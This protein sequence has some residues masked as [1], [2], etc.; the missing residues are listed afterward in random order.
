MYLERKAIDSKDYNV[1]DNNHEYLI[2]EQQP[3]LLILNDDPVLF[4]FLKFHFEKQNRMII[5]EFSEKTNPMELFYKVSPDCVILTGSNIFKVGVHKV[6]RL[7]LLCQENHIPLLVILGKDDL[8]LRQECLVW[9]D[10]IMISPNELDDLVIRVFYHLKKRNRIMNQILI[11]PMTGVKNERFLEQ[12]V[13][14]QLRDIKRY[15]EQFSLVYAQVDDLPNLKNTFGYVIGHQITKELGSFIQKNIRPADS[16]FAFQ[17]EGFILILPKTTKIDAMKLMNRLIEKFSKQSFQTPNGEISTTFSVNVIDFLNSY[18]SVKECLSRMPFSKNQIIADRKGIV[19]DGSAGDTTFRTKK[20][21]IGIIDD[22]R[23]I[24][25][26]L[27]KQLKD[28]DSDYEVEI[29]AFTDGEEFF[30]DSWHLQNERYLL[31]IDRILPK[32]DGL[33]IL[34][35]LRTQYDRRRY[36]CL[37]LTSRDSEIDITLA[38]QRGANDYMT[39]P[40][41]MNELRARIKRLI[42]GSL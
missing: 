11:D 25:E 30:N 38:I 34:E 31:I 18:Q 26:L 27:K 7:A 2:E 36:L 39:K 12:E 17:K 19:M 33:E 28:I 23:L 41:G 5:S 20:L 4:F 6:E 24:R 35:K 22:D 10:D 42:R 1:A 40:F 8:S 13:E 29:K 37:M 14:R 21:R 3:L 16:I 32:M 9:A 15:Y